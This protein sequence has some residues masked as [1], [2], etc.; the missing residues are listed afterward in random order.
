MSV[1]VDR[2]VWPC[3][4]RTSSYDERREWKSKLEMSAD[5]RE[6]IGSLVNKDTNAYSMSKEFH[7][8]IS[9][10]DDD[11]RVSAS[12]ED[13][14]DAEEVEVVDAFRKALIVDDLLPERFD[15]Y[16][17]M[18]RFLKSRK[19][20]VGK[21]KLMWAD[22]IQW[23]KDFGT[24]TILEDFEYT[25]LNEVLQHCS[26]G[27]HG[28]DKQGR[29]VYIERLGKADP[30]MLMRVTTLDRYVKYYV[31]E[32]EKTLRIRFPSCSIAAKRRIDSSTTI[33]DVQDVGLK[34][35]TMSSVEVLRRLQQ[36]D[37]DNYP[38]TLSRM[39]IV[40]AGPGFKMLWKTIKNFLD[41]KSMSKIYVLGNK[42]QSKLLEVI[43]ASELPEF[44]GGCCNCADQG[45]CLRSDKGPWNDVNIRKM[46]YS[47]KHTV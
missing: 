40:N 23:R 36:I 45:G 37:N 25:E 31:Q 32:Y 47:G 15:D 28:V 43:D 2:L 35:L 44:L 14:R 24:D 10:I 9:E 1:T 30:N 27:Y 18:L 42:Y 22:T 46:I 16:H 7:K 29:P 17:M 20:D 13:V 39:F 11:I 41:P 38:E 21:T 5:Q 34:N 26:Q 12:I 33:L 6:N 3:L 19:F 8:K 4:E